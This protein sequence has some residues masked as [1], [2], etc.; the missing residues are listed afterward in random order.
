M[1]V[2][3]PSTHIA[4]P[5]GHI[6]EVITDSAPIIEHTDALSLLDVAPVD[7]SPVPP[8]L[9]AEL[10]FGPKGRGAD[11]VAMGARREP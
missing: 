7:F 4:A 2:A 1:H 6:A 11:R 9:S 10:P 3:A 5:R 8:V